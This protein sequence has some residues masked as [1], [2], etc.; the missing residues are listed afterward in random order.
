MQTTS[1]DAPPALAWRVGC[2][3]KNFDVFASYFNIIARSFIASILLKASSYCCLT[4][5]NGGGNIL[6]TTPAEILLTPK[7]APRPHQTNC[8]R[9]T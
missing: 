6:L 5:R 1:A 3:G 2:L 8:P 9:R 7:S 4:S